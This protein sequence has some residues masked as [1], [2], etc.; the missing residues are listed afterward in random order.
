MEVD[1][2]RGAGTFG[3]R[4]I[5]TATRCGIVVCGSSI[6]C[7]MVRIPCAMARKRVNAGAKRGARS[8]LECGAHWSAECVGVRS[9]L[10]C[11]SH[12]SAEHVGMRSTLEFGVWSALE[13]GA[14]WSA[15]RVGV[16]SAVE[17]G[18]LR[19][20]ERGTRSAGSVKMSADEK[21]AN[22]GAAQL[23]DTTRLLG[24]CGSYAVAPPYECVYSALSVMCGRGSWAARWYQWSLVVVTL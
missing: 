3:D 9:A 5:G 4:H 12:W 22:V 18:A 21:V 2:R 20:A 24:D 7:A 19:S 8:A 14:R 11:G 1:R 23:R 15:E 17:C 13:C 16:R 10:E 6:P